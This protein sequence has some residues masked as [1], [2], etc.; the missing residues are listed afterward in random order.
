MLLGFGRNRTHGRNSQQKGFTTGHWVLKGAEPG[1]TLSFPQSS[2]RAGAW[3]RVEGS[4]PRVCF[5][6]GSPDVEA[7]SGDSG[8]SGLR[9]ESS[10]QNLGQSR[11][12]PTP[13]V[14]W[15][16]PD[17]RGALQDQE[18]HRGKGASLPYPRAEPLDNL[19]G[20]SSS[21]SSWGLG[22]PA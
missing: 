15:V 18:H 2:P 20:I 14:R 9:R 13:G 1:A 11:R 19:P 3:C 10:L 5:R 4:V 17:P 8:E 16:Q 22:G 7:E 6:S 21:H 12:G